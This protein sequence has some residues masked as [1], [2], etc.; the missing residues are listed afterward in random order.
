MK[1]GRVL[2][3]TVGEVEN[4]C[5]TFGLVVVGV[6]SR[7]PVATHPVA[8]HSERNAH[9]LVV[10]VVVGSPVVGWSLAVCF[11]QS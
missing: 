5:N 8:V 2:P 11:A 10:W 9:Q 3:V 7:D 6:A 1:I 4:V